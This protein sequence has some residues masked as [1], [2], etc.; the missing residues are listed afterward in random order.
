M[1]SK[2][3]VLFVLIVS[4]GLFSFSGCGGPDLTPQETTGDALDQYLEEHPEVAAEEFEE[5]DES[6]EE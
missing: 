2:F 6:D 5:D 1:A 4:M 3:Q